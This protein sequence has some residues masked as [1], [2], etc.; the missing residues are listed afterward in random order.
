MVTLNEIKE[1]VIQVWESDHIIL[2]SVTAAQFVLESA[3]GTS[4]LAKQANNFF[5]IKASAP[6]SGPVEKITSNEE[7]D[8]KLV[9]RVSEFRKYGSWEESVQDH[10]DFFVSTAFRKQHYAAVIGELDYKK[11]CTALAK[12][13]ATDS[14]YGTKLIAI[15]EKNG[16]DAW[17][18]IGG[19]IVGKKIFIDDGHGGTDN[20]AVGNGILEDAWNLEVCSLIESEL[21]ALGHQIM[22][23]RSTDV[24][25]GLSERAIMANNWGAEIFISCH[26][27]AGG[28]T[29]YED[30]IYNGVLSGDGNTPGLQQ[31]IHAAVVK[32]IT[33]YGIKD[34]GMK[35]A[36]YSVLRETS[37]PAILLEAGFLD[38]S[39]DAA[40]LKNGQFKKDYA[41]A[42]V[43]GVQ[44][45]F[46]LS[47]S[48][49]P[50]AVVSQVVRTR[51]P[52][53]YNAIVTAAGYSIDSVPWGESGFTQWGKTDDILGNSIYVYEESESGEYINAYQ[54]GWIDKRAITREKQVVASIVHLPNG[55]NWTIYPVE[56]PYTAGDVISLEGANGESA[57][58][59]LGERNG[60]KVLVV[61]LENFGPVGLYYDE[62]KKAY[63]E[64]KYA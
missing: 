49:A 42:V 31:A 34:R 36:N 43:V 13:Y 44:N 6:W 16:L 15:I 48:A 46:G 57:Y 5:G 21:A 22:S 26:V 35:Q 24:F 40:L 30:F 28:G 50:A 23:T 11:V 2:P 39:V 32:V 12:T 53:T 55:K 54:V 63:I 20:G 29:G 38:S 59:V 62:D 56:G 14:S 64:K 33:A 18:G 10:S 61:E 9:P 3:S 52:V 45:Y 51:V 58:T 19:N 4:S 25:V 60:G 47:V 1:K 37:M 17:D 41:H 8:G 7:I 27:N